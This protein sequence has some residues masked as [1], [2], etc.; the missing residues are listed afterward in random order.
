[1][2]ET[3]SLLSFLKVLA[4]NPNFSNDEGFFD[5]AVMTEYLANLKAT[6]PQQYQQWQQYERSVENQVRRE[7]YLNLI[8]A[9]VGSTLLEAE[10]DYKFKNDNVTFQV[11]RI[12]FDKAENVEV[13]SSDIQ[14]YINKNPEQFKQEAQRDIQYVFI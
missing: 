1:M 6:Q 14:A 8:K 12:P 4:G 11:V 3:K 5:E 2:A 10:Q 9:G 7:I 13:T